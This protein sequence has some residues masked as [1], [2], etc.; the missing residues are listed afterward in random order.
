MGRVWVKGQT[1]KMTMR[2]MTAMMIMEY[3]CKWGIIQGWVSKSRKG[4]DTK[5]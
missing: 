3:K 1:M 2:K 4:K 5:A